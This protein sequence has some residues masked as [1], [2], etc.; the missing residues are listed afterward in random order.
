MPERDSASPQHDPDARLGA[1]FENLPAPAHRV[2]TV[3]DA[4]PAPG[5][6]R[7]AREA[8]AAATTPASRYQPLSTEARSA[9]DPAVE[10]PAAS[11]DSALSETEQQ[12]LQPEVAGAAEP[13]V[14]ALGGGLDDL[15]RS[16]HDEHRAA[17]RKKRRTGCVVALI[18]V[19]VLL[20]GIAAG[21]VWVWNTYGDKI[22]DA[23]GWGEPK[24][25]EEGQAGAEVFVTVSEGDNGQ[26]ISTTLYESGVTKTKEAFYEYL[27]SSGNNP[28]FYPGVYRMQEK[29]SSAAALAA[30]T[31]EANRVENS[32]TI[33]EG[34]TAAQAIAAVALAT[35][36]P[37]ADFTAEAANYTQFGIP[38]EAPSIEGYLFPATYTFDPDATAKAVLQRMVDET[39]TRL[40]AL[41]VAEQ[42]RFRILTLAALVQKESGPSAEDMRKIARVFLNRIDIDM[43]LQS[44]ATVAYG[45]GITG[46]VWTTPEQREDASNLYNTYVH[47]GLPAGPISLPGEEALKAAIDPADGSWLYFVAV[48]LRTGET[49]FSDTYEQHLDAVDQLDAWCRVDENKPYCA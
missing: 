36:I 18:I 8:A 44:D 32:V 42:D 14:P 24:D 48:D 40:D 20:G 27:I 13:G 16:E 28:T 12:E 37:E 4:P 5:S 34:Y 23:M 6:R 43:L 33:P 30:I 19:L 25:W 22:S 26:S 31:D 15:F 2:P 29:M 9:E 21:G 49:L 3:D 7:A 46:T 35:G 47:H 17:P 11:M 38:A 41:G 10:D 39:Y 1:L 45:A